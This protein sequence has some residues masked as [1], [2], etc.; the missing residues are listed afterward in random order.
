MPLEMWDF[1]EN[2]LRNTN[3]FD[4]QPDN[5]GSRWMSLA[6]L[7]RGS[8]PVDES[9]DP[10][11]PHDNQS[12]VGLA[13]KKRLESALS[14]PGRSGVQDNEIIR[15]FVMNYGALYTSI[16]YED[17]FYDPVN[18]SYAFI[19]IGSSNH[20]VDIVGWDDAYSR[21]NFKVPVGGDGAFIC[22]NSFGSSWGENGYFYVSYYDT[23]IG[24]GNMAFTVGPEPV[25]AREYGYDPLGFTSPFGIVSGTEDYN[26]T[27]WCG[28]VFT[29]ASREDLTAV[30]FYATSTM[31]EYQF[32]I[33]LDPT[34][35]PVNPA[36]AVSVTNGSVTWPGYYTIQLNKSVRLEPGQK[37]SVVARLHTPYSDTPLAIE[38]RRP[39]YNSNASI[40]AGRCFYSGKGTNWYDIASDLQAINC[41]KGFTVPTPPD[42]LLRVNN[43]PATMAA[44]ETSSFQVIAQNTGGGT[45][46]RSYGYVLA[47]VNYTTN[48]NVAFGAAKASLQDVAVA[49]GTGY[50]IG[51]TLQAPATPGTYKVM[52]RMLR[53]N[54]TWFGE[55]LT[56]Q[57]NVTGPGYHAKVVASDL[58]AALPSGGSYN[59][60][61][62]VNNTGTTAWSEAAQVRL[63]AEGDAVKF[64]AAR[65]S[66][67]S[68]TTVQPGQ[69]YTW[70]I[71]LTAPAA[72]G[73]YSVR[74]RLVANNVTSFGEYLNQTITVS[75]PRYD[76]SVVSITAGPWTTPGTQVPVSVTMNNTGNVPW[77]AAV[78]VRLTPLGD[79]A[80]FSATTLDL[81]AVVSVSPGG[82]YTWNFTLTSPDIGSYELKYRLYHSTTGFGDTASRAIVVINTPMPD[83]AAISNTIP[84]SMVKGR[85]YSVTVT[86]KNTGNIPWSASDQFQLSAGGSAAQF[87]GASIYMPPGTT[88]MPN[89]QYTFKFTMVAPS[90]TGSYT[91]KYRMKWENDQSFGNSAQKTV[92]V[93]TGTAT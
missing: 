51:V 23:V 82:R 76:A 86:M 55:T 79:A 43:Y 54:Q 64:G 19:G 67:P 34:N 88:V 33:Y 74:Y 36:G 47:P 4:P 29:A 3:G 92:T 20:A 38:Q 65:Y 45:W 80:S 39:G 61:I 11:D 70:K 8:G 73:S 77:S 6:Y 69:Q 18:H 25:N 10:Y 15:Y 63:G 42:A 13:P 93:K 44:G 75:S 21:H 62:T 72:G 2:H 58:P 78:P 83:A 59:A 37:F 53:E 32:N 41:L 22:R 26:N 46:L 28:N 68:G 87:S 17:A 1:S 71:T 30:G 57:I 89:E 90:T 5:S 52:Y 84:T 31:C 35:G 48:D 16:H 14:L 40:V 81:P 50:A 91:V 7:A 27:N 60:S 9:A 85:T 49:P 56:L 12:P 66:L 24:M